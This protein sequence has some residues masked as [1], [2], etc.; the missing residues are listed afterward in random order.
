MAK[1]LTPDSIPSSPC[2]LSTLDDQLNKE[3]WVGTE[4]C[5]GADVLR[6]RAVNWAGGCCNN[7][8]SSRGSDDGSSDWSHRYPE[9]NP[10]QL[11]CHLPLTAVTTFIL[12]LGP[13]SSLIVA[14]TLAFTV[15]PLVGLLHRTG[16][17]LNK[18]VVCRGRKLRRRLGPLTLV[19]M[20]VDLLFA[21]LT[22]CRPD[23]LPVSSSLL[24]CNCKLGNIAQQQQYLVSERER[25]AIALDGCWQRWITGRRRS[26]RNST[27][28]N[29][30]RRTSSRAPSRA[31]N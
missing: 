28:T 4:G 3:N 6:A 31:N 14:T 29:K 9:T 5:R 18:Y 21:C 30:S 25:L 11:A 7:D 24:C 8:G 20:F 2:V 26:V 22:A 23:R 10:R 13:F 16:Y 15:S 12:R 17:N 1:S 27:P 19:D